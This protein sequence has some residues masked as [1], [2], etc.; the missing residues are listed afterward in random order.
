M[1]LSEAADS[2]AIIK[3]HKEAHGLILVDILRV[4]QGSIKGAMSITT[5]IGLSID[6]H[7]GQFQKNAGFET[8]GHTFVLY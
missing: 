7:N 3:T 2:N 4:K 1:C 5:L 6:W 8:V